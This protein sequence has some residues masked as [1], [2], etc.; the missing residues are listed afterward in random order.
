MDLSQLSKDNM[1]F[2]T[3]VLRQ[4]STNPYGEINFT[5]K[6]HKGKAGTMQT[7]EFYSEKFHEGNNAIP[8][9]QVIELIKSMIDKKESG[10][11]TFTLVFGNGYI[12]EIVHQSHHKKNY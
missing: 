9:A 12:K 5:V 4:I 6:T 7:Q 1:A 8:T 10:T 11:V 2:V 3:D